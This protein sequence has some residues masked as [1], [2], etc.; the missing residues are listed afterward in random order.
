M[1]K[2]RSSML[3]G[4]LDCSRRAIASGYRD[5]VQ[6]AG[7]RLNERDPHVGACIGT[8]AHSGSEHML[9]N[10]EA[11]LK[12]SIEVGIESFKKESG[13][14]LILD[15]LTPDKNT[16]EYQVKALVL[17][18]SQE[19]APNVKPVMYNGEIGTEIYL[20]AMIDDETMLTGHIDLFDEIGMAPHDSKFGGQNKNYFPQLGGYSKL[21]GPNGLTVKS[22]PVIDWIPRCKKGKVPEYHRI[23]YDRKLCEEA[24]MMICKKIK[25]DVARFLKTGNPWSFM[26]NVNSML[27][28]NKFCVAHGTNFCGL[29]RGVR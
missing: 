24:G 18:Y 1:L 25:A 4:Y 2:I 7:Y 22:D 26:P 11:D 23:T 9:R 19:V 16:A 29:T 13:G 5:M 6:D 20:K 21:S 10:P 8:G 3:N 17:T 14:D 12:D 15:A 27:C 28:S